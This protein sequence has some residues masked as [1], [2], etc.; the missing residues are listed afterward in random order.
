MQCWPK[1]CAG[2]CF[3]A[4]AE[5]DRPAANGAG[6]GRRCSDCLATSSLALRIATR[7]PISIPG[8]RTQPATSKTALHQHRLEQTKRLTLEQQLSASDQQHSHELSDAQRDQLAC[9]TVL[10]LL[11][12][13]CQSSS[14]PSIRPMAA[15]CLP[16]PP[17]AVWFMQPRQP[18]LTRRML[19]ELSPS[20]TTAITP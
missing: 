20:P 8:R 16:L 14:T 12:Y 4:A 17:P 9:G 3:D 1:V 7:T 5:I 18:D 10:P 15:Q 2:L 6:H 19:S 11:I 13:G